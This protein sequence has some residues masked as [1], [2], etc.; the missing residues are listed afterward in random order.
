MS[1]PGGVLTRWALGLLVALVAVTSTACAG[2]DM[3]VNGIRKNGDNQL[4]TDMQP[5]VKRLPRLSGAPSAQW[6]SGHL[7][8]DRVPGPTTHW[9]DAVVAL[10]DATLQEVS[11]LPGLE[12]AGAP[13]VVQGLEASMPE[14]DLQ[15]SD[16]LDKFFTA[17]PWYVEAWL[18]QDSNQV[19]LLVQGGS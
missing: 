12:V 10:D 9:I 4:R 16:A 3:T 1:V 7:G 18:A 11:A 17:A 8:D 14:G 5:L 2:P 19:V 15:R 13:P 6:M